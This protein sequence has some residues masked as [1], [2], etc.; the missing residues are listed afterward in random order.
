[1]NISRRKFVGV[2]TG[3]VAIVKA[4]SANAFEANENGYNHLLPEYGPEHFNPGKYIEI[5]KV[6]SASHYRKFFQIPDGR[7]VQEF[8]VGI[9]KYAISVSAGAN[10]PS[11]TLY[12]NNG[13]GIHR[14]KYLPMERIDVPSWILLKYLPKLKM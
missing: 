7:I 3:L 8:Y 2:V 14:R 12:D 6:G 13:D 4:Y 5:G 10:S 1:M 9:D 11:F